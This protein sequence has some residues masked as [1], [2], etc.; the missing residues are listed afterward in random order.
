MEGVNATAGLSL[1]YD[2]NVL[3]KDYHS[4]QKAIVWGG[5]NVAMDCARSLRRILQD[6]TVVYR[7]SEKE[8]PAN[9]SEILEAKAEGVRFRF[10]SNVKGLVLDEEGKV[11]AARCIRMELGEPDTSGRAAPH[12]VAGSE[13]EL[14]VD[15]FV[16]AIGQSVDLQVLDPQLEKGE[17][18]LSSLPKVYLCGDAYL[19]PKTVAAAIT[20]GRLAAAEILAGE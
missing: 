1:L 7:R 12:E 20:D 2:L 15:L 18:H 13:E 17:T 5:G 14:S 4:F 3:R 8:M 19:G 16:S 11:R 10:L 6:V 9:R